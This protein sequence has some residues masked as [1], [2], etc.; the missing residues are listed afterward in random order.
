VIFVVG[1]GVDIFVFE[2]SQIS[3]LETPTLR[4]GRHRWHATREGNEKGDSPRPLMKKV[5]GGSHRCGCYNDG[6]G[7]RHWR[8]RRDE[9]LVKIGKGVR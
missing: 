1:S 9:A 4:E 5:R 7:A 8:W 3:I 6:V 2:W